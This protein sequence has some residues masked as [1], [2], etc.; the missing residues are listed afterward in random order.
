MTRLTDAL[1]TGTQNYFQPQKSI[2]LADAAPSI[3]SQIQKRLAVL[4]GTVAFGLPLILAFG[5]TVGGS[6]FRDSISHFYYAQFLGPIFV[7]LLIFIGGFLIAYTGE[8]WLEDLGSFIA[9]LGA[10]F[11]AVFPTT[12]N[13]CEGET[14]FLSRLFVQY[15][16]GAHPPIAA[17]EGR[18]FFQLFE[19]V[20]N[21]HLWAAGLLFSYLGLYC[22]FVL[23]RVVPDRH[24]R[25][26]KLIQSKRSRNILYSLCGITI[27]LCIAVLGAKGYV[28]QKNTDFLTRIHC[29]FHYTHTVRR[30]IVTLSSSHLPSQLD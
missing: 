26:G 10:F 24:I 3:D 8:H 17:V 29:L 9:G 2:T 19:S 11:V 1:A 21:L 25:D 20:E 28:G 4:V 14:S 16:E 6:C 5:G 13:G 18:N 15:T 30:I 27:L 7:G 12:G 22:L 23:K